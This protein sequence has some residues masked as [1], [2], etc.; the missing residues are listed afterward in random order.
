MYFVNT[1][2]SL[3]T[4]CYMNLHSK[5]S[6]RKYRSSYHLSGIKKEE[7]KRHNIR[8]FTIQSTSLINYNIVHKL[9]LPTS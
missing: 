8:T 7:R 3:L 9:Y 4:N 1:L 2:H 5:K 6:D